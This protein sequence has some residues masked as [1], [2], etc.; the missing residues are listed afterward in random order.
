MAR[1]IRFACTLLASSLLLAPPAQAGWE[2]VGTPGFS[3]ST[4]NYESFT[5]CNGEP[6]VAFQDA[7][8]TN[9]ATVM[10]YTGGSWQVVG[11]AG[12]SAG[13]AAYLSLAFNGEEPYVAFQ[14]ATVSSKATV[15]CYSG[16][17]WQ[18][19]GTAGISAGTATYTSLAI[20][21]GE[22]YVAYR[23][24]GTSN[25][26]LVKRYTGGAW[27]TV[28]GTGASPSTSNYVTLAF[29]NGEAYVA[30]QDSSN[31]SRA[32]VRRFT[33][34]S[35]QTV[36]SA[37]F[38]AGTATHL[39]LAFDNGEPY[40]A[41]QDAGNGTR[42]TVMHYTGGSWQTVGSAGFSAGVAA[43]ESIALYNGE[44]YVLYQDATNGSRATVMR[45]TGGNWQTVGPAGFSTG[46]RYYG[47]IAF[48]NGEPYIAYR[49]SAL[50][51]K[52]VVLRYIWPPTIQASNVTLSGITATQMNVS[53]TRG[54]GSACAV[55]MSQASSG[56]AA[57]ADNTTYA[58]STTFGNGMQIGTTGWFC[59]YVGSG[60]N[61][62][63]TGLT[64]A[65][66]YRVMVCEYT[67][68]VGKQ[69]YLLGA[70]TENPANVATLAYPPT[71]T[72]AAVTDIGATTAVCGGEVASDGGATVFARGVCWNTTG[73]PTTTDNK[74]MDGTGTGVFAST[75]TSLN[76]GATY[77]VRAYATNVQGTSYGAEVEFTANP[78]PSTVNTAAVTN[79]GSTTATCG[80]VVTADGGVAVTAR[81]VCWNTT[82][83]PTTADSFTTDGAGTGAFVSSLTGLNPNLTHY[84]RAY[85]TNS[86]GTS[87]GTEVAFTTDT[88]PPAVT[89][90]A[91]TNVTADTSTCGGN[92]TGDGGLAIDA[93]GVC[94]NTSGNPTTA[95]NSTTD[96]AGL[97]A[98]VSSLTSLTPGI[99]YH[100]RAYATNARGTSYGDDVQFTTGTTLPT[101]TTAGVTDVTATTVS[102]GGNV[103]SDGGLEVTERGVCWNTT[104]NPT[105]ADSNT[106]NGTGAGTFSVSI[107]SLNPNTTYHVRAY[108]I[109]ALGANYGHDVEFLT[110]AAPP[111]V[112][113]SAVMGVTSTTAICGG[114]VTDDGMAAIATRGVCWNTTGNP[115]TADNKTAD[116]AGLGTF[117]SSLTDLSPGVGYYVR[118]YAANAQSTG[119]GDTVHFTTGSVPPTVATAAVTGVSAT[120]ACCGGNV[121]SD[122]G[123]QVAAR[124]VSWSKADDPTTAHT[125]TVD[126]TGI[127]AFT[128]TLVDLSP[129]TLYLVRAYATNA[130]GISF[131]S[132]VE[133]RTGMVS[134]TVVTSEVMGVTSTTAMCGGNVTADGLAEV[135]T[136]GVC[137]NTTGNPTTA[138]RKTTD[139]AGTGV[140]ISSL[141]DLS[142][143]VVYYARAYATNAQS[144]GYGEQVDFVTATTAPTVTTTAVTNVTATTAT[145]GGHVTANGGA[146]LSARGVWWNKADEPTTAYSK[147][148][149]D[150]TTGPFALS[151]TGLSPDTVY[152]VRAFAENPAGTSYG[153]ALT[154]TTTPSEVVPGLV[155]EAAA[156]EGNPNGPVTVGQELRLL[157]TVQNAG[158]ARAHQVTVIIPIPPRTEYVSARLIENTAV[159]TV[160]GD[161]QSGTLYV[162]LDDLTPGERVEVELVLRVTAAG[163]IAVSAGAWSAQHTELVL[164]APAQITA[165]E[166]SSTAGNLPAPLTCGATGTL[167]L[168]ACLTAWVAR[169]SS[170]RT[171]SPPS[172]SARRQEAGEAHRRTF[173]TSRLQRP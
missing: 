65:A 134:P 18:L 20:H 173:R 41:Y 98:F 168:L 102:C 101:V 68:S 155:V 110:S 79:V 33:G 103:T 130:R 147:T 90:A 58:A 56:E 96:G 149:D 111:T 53:W 66:A 91:V 159:P 148:V 75:L 127:G 80:G 141:T 36:G 78:V 118:A 99:T 125:K 164:S 43:Y 54:D 145:C 162:N 15:M 32:T 143:G 2:P 95:D 117:V 120:Q 163:Q 50:A 87:Y 109:N 13:T 26:T 142:P 19:V 25:R 57:P 121:V 108:A 7:S 84:A 27:Q 132:N 63:V 46:A 151:L 167:P 31:G 21:N 172:R 17:S 129:N 12:F 60:A 131:G 166:D 86:Q 105:T 88:G 28:G 100:V 104:G 49:D 89:T 4:A 165:R 107:A 137:W 161:L 30:Y 115:T 94:W 153:E 113:T 82:G 55:F 83:N 156:A 112:T 76:P 61:V 34:G 126:S 73:T 114:A 10:R 22:P 81:G 116:G 9:K 128:V 38:S 139:G 8:Q 3:S 45:Y 135:T 71:V 122:G 93:R 85:A 158:T 16:G 92:V 48:F 97:G 170:L 14:D 77:H 52:A 138:D 42:A 40:V 171:C 62:T 150:T 39:S 106:V 47:A 169:Y 59:L 37:G 29:D 70:A 5:F 11:T 24:A 144:T 67:G 119:Y 23:D 74:T 157:I 124:G 146:E 160:L 64:P 1:L 140:F 123:T 35:W 69:D 44:P 154:F 51:S 133:F 152:H 72:T 136:R 6:Y